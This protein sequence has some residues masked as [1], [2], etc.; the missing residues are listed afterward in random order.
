MGRGGFVLMREHF[1]PAAGEVRW[2]AEYPTVGED[3]Q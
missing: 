3:T 2:Q 1:E